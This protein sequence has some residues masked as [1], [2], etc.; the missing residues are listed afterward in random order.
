MTKDFKFQA[1]EIEKIV[2]DYLVR[3]GL[4][5]SVDQV[6]YCV[7]FLTG[8]LNDLL[9]EALKDGVRVYG[10]G[11]DPKD[12]W[13]KHKTEYDTHKAFLIQIETIKGEK[14]GSK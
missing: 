3:D 13:T 12:F 14:C 7:N 2:C 1:A 11:G 6:N 5:F 10:D 4:S 9:A 8:Q